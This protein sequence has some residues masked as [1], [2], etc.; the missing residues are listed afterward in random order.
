MDTT[1]ANLEQFLQDTLIGAE[2]GDGWSPIEN[3]ATYA[4][5]GVLTMDSGL[6]VRLADGS[7]FQITIVK[8]A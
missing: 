4:D 7:E 5:Q 3:V 8:S 2:D 6:I 1:A